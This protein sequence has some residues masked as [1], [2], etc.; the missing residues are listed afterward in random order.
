M[1]MWCRMSQWEFGSVFMGMNRD[2][3][4]GDLV[5]AWTLRSGRCSTP[6]YLVTM[7]LIKP[8]YIWSS[9]HGSLRVCVSCLLK[10][11]ANLGRR[12]VSMPSVSLGSWMKILGVRSQIHFV[13]LIKTLSV[14]M[15]MG[16]CRR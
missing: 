7:N 2:L 3:G 4:E 13:D 16:M 15:K 6:P 14:L 1:G 12:V 10:V 11:E 9:G 5:H 8:W